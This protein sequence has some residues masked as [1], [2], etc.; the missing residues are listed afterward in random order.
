MKIEIKL[1]SFWSVGSGK[2]GCSLDSIV[3][4]DK[5]NLPYIPGRTF[6]GLLRDA[7]NECGYKN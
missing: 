3:L 2:V 7:Y 1:Y 4:R 6:K 5:D